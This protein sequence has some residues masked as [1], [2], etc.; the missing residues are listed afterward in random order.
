MTR[1]QKKPHTTVSPSGSSGLDK[2]VGIIFVSRA[3][4]IIAQMLALVILTRILSKENFSLIAF[5]LLTYSTVLTLGQL[6]LADSIFYFFHKLAPELRRALTLQTG[7]ALFV[8]SLFCAF[9][10]L[11]IQFSASLWGRELHGLIWPFMLLVVLELP[12][13][14]MPNILI[15]I[16]QTKD[17][18]ILN[19]LVGI[20]QLLALVLPLILGYPLAFVVYSLLGYGALRFLFSGYLFLKYFKTKGPELPKG[21][22]LEQFKYSLPLSIAQIIWGLNRQI[23]KYVVAFFFTPVVFAE[24]IVGAWEIPL[25]GIIA[26][27]FASVLMPQLVSFHLTGQKENLLVLWRNSIQKVSV[28]V[29]PLVVL[30]LVVAE[31]FI[32]LL[33]SEKYLP[34]VLPFRI[35]TVIIIQRVAVYNSLLKAIDETRA[36]T[37]AA[38]YLLLVNMVLNIPLLLL[39]GIVG[40]PIA[41][42][43]ANLFAGGYSLYKIKTK[44][45]STLNEVFPFPFYL[46][47]LIIAAAAAIPTLFLKYQL[48]FSYQVN[49]AI[50][51][52]CYFLVY[53]ITASAGGI[54]KK[55]D[56]L[57]LLL[58]VKLKSV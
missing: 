52:L 10:L 22:L 39:F 50:L 16:D 55:E 56:W 36:V 12:T 31:E 27:S 34:A 35:Y 37:R 47:T 28:I 38:I 53:L 5:L 21:T 57:K 58:I 54:I 7:R 3:I 49:L 1:K 48:D 4:S 25:I 6:G 9:I 44:L 33:A 51:T 45:N 24:Y 15:A 46:R 29:L 41:T 14:P 30:F 17:A 8:I 2:K 32:V 26:S 11:I 20:T 40:P 43:T 23:D 13:L 42:L 19:I 18:G